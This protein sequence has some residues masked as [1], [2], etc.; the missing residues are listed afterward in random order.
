MDSMKPRRLKNKRM[1]ITLFL[2]TICIMLSLNG[3]TTH[4]DRYLSVRL[5]SPRKY[6]DSLRSLSQYLGNG[7]CEWLAPEKLDE[8]HTM[9][10]TTLLAS[11]PGSG[12]RLAWRILEALTGMPE[13]HEKQ[14]NFCVKHLT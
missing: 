14:C 12:K 4:F 8:S 13:Y 1:I 6:G 3:K 9:N 7:Q 10:T 5:K 2:F 11:Y